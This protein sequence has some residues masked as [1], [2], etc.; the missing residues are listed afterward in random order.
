MRPRNRL[1][2][3]ALAVQTGF[4][5]RSTSSVVIAST[6]FSAS[7]AAYVVSVERHCVWCFSLRQPLSKEA[8]TVRRQLPERRNVGFCPPRLD[9]IAPLGYVS[10]ALRRPLACHGQRD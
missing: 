4:K 6:R 1:A 7:G 3:S 10:S 8:T 5:T 2:V 9:W